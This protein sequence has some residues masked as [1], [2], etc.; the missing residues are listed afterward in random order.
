MTIGHENG[1]ARG[2]N[3][4]WDDMLDGTATP[5]RGRVEPGTITPG[6]DRAKYEWRR[7][8]RT[9]ETGAARNDDTEKPDP[10]G[11]LSPLV[12]QRYCQYMHKNRIQENGERRDSDNWQLGIPMDEYMKSLFRHFLEVWTAHR[13]GYVNEEALCAVLFNAMGYLH[14]VLRKDQGDTMDAIAI[15][16][17]AD[18]ATNP[19]DYCE[20]CGEHRP[21]HHNCSKI[22]TRVAAC[23]FDNCRIVEQHSHATLVAAHENS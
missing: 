1:G 10:E 23:T 13:R 21:W 11:F 16:V 22:G 18:R 3:Q 2:P 4:L 9:F 5:E 12:L 6:D 17:E 15:Q 20:E 8:L 14:E 7:H 19:G